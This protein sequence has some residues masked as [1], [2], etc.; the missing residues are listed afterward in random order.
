M[1]NSAAL[2]RGIRDAKIFTRMHLLL[3]INRKTGD[4][5]P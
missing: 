3:F 1:Q 2:N 4:I 5:L